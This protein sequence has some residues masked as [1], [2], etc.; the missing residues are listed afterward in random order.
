MRKL[1]VVLFV[2]TGFCARYAYAVSVVNGSMTDVGGDYN[3]VN[4]LVPSGWQQ[5]PFTS[6]DIFD[7]NTNFSNFAWSASSDGG[8]F[9]HALGLQGPFNTDEGIFQE[10]TGLIIGESYIVSFEQ[11][12]SFSS[13]GLQGDGGYFD[14][15]FGNET[16]QST[17]MIR[18]DLGVK[19]DWQ[20]QSLMFTATSETL[21]PA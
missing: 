4:A 10:I 12:I 9:V 6:P 17:N 11:S 18:P 5:I 16:K 19:A 21:T 14:V 8:T 13:T 1:L 15:T 3:S 2:C 7:E 20:N